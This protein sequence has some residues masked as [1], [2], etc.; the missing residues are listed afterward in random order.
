MF[1][2]CFYPE[3]AR[4]LSYTMLFWFAPGNSQ[5][6]PHNFRHMCFEPCCLLLIL[7]QHLHT[8]RS[9][10]AWGVESHAG[11]EQTRPAISRGT[12]PPLSTRR[13]TARGR[14]WAPELWLASS[15]A[16]A[17]EGSGGQAGPAPR[18]AYFLP[19]AY[20]DA[21]SGVHKTGLHQTDQPPSSPHHYPRHKSWQKALPRPPLTA[22]TIAA[23]KAF[24][25]CAD[26]INLML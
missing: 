23:T 5:L 15:P 20:A 14:G 16:G 17:A 3:C 13:V 24:S 1:L 6:L 12:S 19:P 21:N 7:P 2:P 26:D 8:L 11:G 22:R 9:S 25:A 10:G 4:L 18:H